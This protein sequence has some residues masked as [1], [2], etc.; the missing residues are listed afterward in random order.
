M[1]PHLDASGIAVLMDVLKRKNDEYIAEM[2]KDEQE[3]EIQ[4]SDEDIV[5]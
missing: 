3:E 2:N 4:N 5:L 1:I